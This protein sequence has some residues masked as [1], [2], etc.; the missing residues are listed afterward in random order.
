RGRTY[1]QI[2]LNRFCRSSREPRATVRS[3]SD[4]E[5]LRRSSGDM[6]VLRLVEDL[7]QFFET[8]RSS[9]ADA[10]L[11][12]PQGVANLGITRFIRI[13]VK[14]FDEPPATFGKLLEC[15]FNGVFP[16]NDADVLGDVGKFFVQWFPSAPGAGKGIDSPAGNSDQPCGQCRGI[17]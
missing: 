1:S 7:S 14:G 2:A 8:T 5:Q 12:H 9:R 15:P 4:S 6:T 10:C 13:E 17:S 11:G 16:F 3:R